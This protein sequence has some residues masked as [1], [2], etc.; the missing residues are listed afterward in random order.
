MTTKLLKRF[1]M[2][3][4]AGMV[5]FSGAC[6]SIDDDRIP[7]LAVSI[8]LNDAGLWNAYGTPGVGAYQK[9]IRQLKQPA[10]FFYAADSYTGFGGVLLIY[11]I[12][13]FSN[14]FCP[15]AYDLACPVECKA[16][17]RVNFDTNTYEAICPS[18]DSH[19]NVFDAGGVP[20]SGPAFTGEHK[21]GLRRY[22]CIP[23]E[24]GGYIIV[25]RY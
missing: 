12:D 21:Y 11:G 25:N 2:Y 1:V 9:F 6:N 7:N 19:Y 24:F 10:G 20:I 23:T 13:P 15:L 4:A 16:D 5:L 3:A 17:V 8:K 22:N 18:C 14:D